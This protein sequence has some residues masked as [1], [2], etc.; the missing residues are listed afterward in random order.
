MKKFSS[1]YLG[2]SLLAFM[3]E[4]A[5]LWWYLVAG[6]NLA[7]SFKLFKKHNKEYVL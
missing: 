5:Y 7:V 6:V 4:S 3:S 2:I 1:I